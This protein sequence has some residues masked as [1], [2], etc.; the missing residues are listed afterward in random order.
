MENVY[1]FSALQSP[2][3]SL[4]GMGLTVCCG[5]TRNCNLLQSKA[6]KPTLTQTVKQA[7][8]IKKHQ[9][10]GF[11][12]SFPIFHSAFFVWLCN[13]IWFYTCFFFCLHIFFACGIKMIQES[14]EQSWQK[15]F[16]F[17]FGHKQ[18]IKSHIS[19]IFCVNF[20]LFIFLTISIWKGARLNAKK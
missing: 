2:L 19:W 12:F 11:L 15:V 9:P 14:C 16:P 18:I 10:V 8:I 4:C 5:S 3:Q 20:W 13:N 7:A 6:I 1:I 17:F